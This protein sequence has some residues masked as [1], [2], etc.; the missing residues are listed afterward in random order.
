MVRNNEKVDGIETER[1]CVLGKTLELAGPHFD[2][3][4]IVHDVV[5]RFEATVVEVLVLVDARIVVVGKAYCKHNKS[6]SRVRRE[7]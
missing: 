3:V 7:V 6:L 5:I 1:R 2:C 4:V